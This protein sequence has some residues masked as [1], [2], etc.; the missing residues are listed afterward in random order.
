MLSFY[1]L[2]ISSLNTTAASL[3]V[4]NTVVIIFKAENKPKVTLLITVY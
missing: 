2:D 1:A 4:I 3:F